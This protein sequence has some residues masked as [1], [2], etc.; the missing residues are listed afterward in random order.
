MPIPSEF[1]PE[2]PSAYSP[3]LREEAEH[4]RLAPQTVYSSFSS[5]RSLVKVAPV[6]LL[7]KKSF[8]RPYNYL[9]HQ[10]KLLFYFSLGGV[11][12]K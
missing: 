11:D 6:R 10:E 3:Q 1:P 4:R 8:G 7:Q 9:V 5:T 2:R 12:N